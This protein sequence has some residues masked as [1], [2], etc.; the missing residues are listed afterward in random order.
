MGLKRGDS[1]MRERRKREKRRERR[2]R[3]ERESLLEFL[4]KSM[5]ETIKKYFLRIPFCYSSII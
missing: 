5:R 4:I 2:K 1:K 3:V